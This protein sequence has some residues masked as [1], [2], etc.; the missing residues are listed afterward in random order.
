M[1]EGQTLKLFPGIPRAWME[2]GNHIELANVASYFG[3]L[4]VR[5][6]S[7]LEQNL[8]EANVECHSDRPPKRIELRLPH[9]QGKRAGNVT[10]GVYEK[11]HEVIL[12]EPFDGSAHI[13][14]EFGGY[15]GR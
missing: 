4:S 2:D 10:G 8:I 13:T 12:I 11:Q 15:R 5:V 7:K 1:E 3:P 6:E 14:L 9:P